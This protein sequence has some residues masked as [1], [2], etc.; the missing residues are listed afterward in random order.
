MKRT[1]WAVTLTLAS[2][3]AADPDAPDRRPSNVGPADVAPIPTDRNSPPG[4]PDAAPADQGAVPPPPRPDLALAEP[5]AGCGAAAECTKL[6][7]ERLKLRIEPTC[8]PFHVPDGATALRVSDPDTW[9]EVV[10]T[11][12]WGDSN[13]LPEV[14]WS[15]QEIVGYRADIECPFG[16]ELL[17]AEACGDALVVH[18][19]TWSDLCA[20][21]YMESETAS[22]NAASTTGSSSRCTRKRRAPRFGATAANASGSC[23]PA[24]SAAA[25]SKPA[26]TTETACRPPPGAAGADPDPR[27]PDC[28]ARRPGPHSFAQMPES[29]HYHHGDLRNALLVGVAEA[30]REQGPLTL[31]LRA[32]RTPTPCSR[33]TP[34]TMQAWCGALSSFPPGRLPR[35][36]AR[37]FPESGWFAPRRSWPGGRSAAV[38]NGEVSGACRNVRASRVE[39]LPENLQEFVPTALPPQ[40]YT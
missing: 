11:C 14:D 37:P 10:R 12:V 21:D 20:C 3:C 8:D 38:A 16:T 1:A 31:S 39:S 30:I 9:A 25:A 27:A 33:S 13:V 6:E 17:G 32:R 4:H 18:R 40:S 29:R 22:S 15:S 7:I 5:D 36:R 35:A 2:A 34:T 26:A 28:A 24:R 23:R 19:W